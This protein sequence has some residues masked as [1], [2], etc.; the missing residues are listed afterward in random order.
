MQRRNFLRVVGGGSIAAVGLGVTAW[1][2][3]PTAMPAQAIAAWAGPDANLSA[4]QDIRH[5]LLSYA[6]LAPHAHNLQSWR[7]DLSQDN[8][9]ILYCD[10]QRL[11]P[12]TDPASRQIMLSHG[13]FLEVLDLAAKSHGLQ[14]D[15]T[16]FPDGVF[17]AQAIDKRP[18]ARITLKK[19]ASASADLLFDQV[20]HRHTNRGLYDPG[21]P[22]RPEALV[23]M[24][25]AAGSGVAVGFA[26]TS[27][28]STF[29]TLSEIARQA[30]R[31]ELVTPRTVMESM[32]LLR[33]GTDE[34]ARHRDGI[35]LLEPL[36]VALDRFGLL[37]R[38][39]P[40][41][42]AA[43]EA[44]IRGFNDKIASTPN[45]LWLTTP[46]NDRPTQI[47]AGRAYVRAQLAATLHGLSFHPVS[48]ALQE[49]EEQAP[50]YARVHAV[51]G[52]STQG[53]TVQMWVRLGYASATVPSPRRG[54][55]ALLGKAQT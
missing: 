39:Q 50:W 19:D 13:A 34:V 29:E 45:Y 25:N 6:L 32:D 33:V 31:V 51:T 54:L 14:A 8:T 9:I 44:Q 16:L 53:S 17:P 35:S 38:H 10:L 23:A 41:S 55:Q 48:Q 30:W 46:G 47:A 26:G 37:D 52:A 2:T 40:P 42:G 24:R 15:I 21:R 20:L 5:R 11:L 12:Q 49:Y 18:V 22:A 1:A 4:G 36:P 3:L 28:A 27:D 43:L 7:V